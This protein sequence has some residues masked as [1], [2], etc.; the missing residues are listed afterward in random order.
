MNLKVICLLQDLSNA[1]RNCA[2]FARFQSTLAITE[3][4]VQYRHGRDQQTG[5]QADTCSNNPHLMLCIDM[6]PKMNEN[7]HTVKTFRRYLQEVV[8][9]TP[10]DGPAHH[11]GQ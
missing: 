5:K 10:T 6:R 9:F 11:A 3:L 7:N 1:I 2:T 4:L 8:K